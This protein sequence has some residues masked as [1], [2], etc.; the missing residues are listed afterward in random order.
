MNLVIL[1]ILVFSVISIL[2]NTYA[3]EIKDFI[4]HS[5]EEFGYRKN[6]ASY[7]EIER[8]A[9]ESYQSKGV[10][11]EIF[12]KYWEK[13]LKQ[14]SRALPLDALHTIIEEFTTGELD[15]E[16]WKN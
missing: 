12:A 8:F 1:T 4:A 3:Q 9:L 15:P 14:N 7:E 5:K 6:A 2:W 10:T 11:K 13:E 16:I